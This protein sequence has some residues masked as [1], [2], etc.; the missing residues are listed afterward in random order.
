VIGSCECANGPGNVTQVGYIYAT[1][2]SQT[3]ELNSFP[4]LKHK[5][6]VPKYNINNINLRLILI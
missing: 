2:S 6:E 3:H 4:L 1:I 5:L